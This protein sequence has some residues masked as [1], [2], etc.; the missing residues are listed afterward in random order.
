MHNFYI[1]CVIHHTRGIVFAQ[2]RFIRLGEHRSLFHRFFC[3]QNF[4]FNTLNKT[5]NENL[6]WYINMM[7]QTLGF[8]LFGSW[9]KHR[10]SVL[11]KPHCSPQLCFRAQYV[12]FLFL[13]LFL[14]HLKGVLHLLPQKAQKIACVVLYLKIR[15]IFL[16]NNI[17]IL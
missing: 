3:C 10:S 6:N 16:K 14:D 8:I 7:K 1:I 9:L 13:F 11:L 12:L 17:C 2:I 4:L 5:D 15:N